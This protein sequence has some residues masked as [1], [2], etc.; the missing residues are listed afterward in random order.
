MAEI[1]LGHI[2]DGR[3][4]RVLDLGCG[5]GSLV[6][7]IAQA[8][9]L[10]HVV[11]LDI[12]AAN[13]RAAEASRLAS[14]VAARVAFERADYLAFHSEPFDA[15]VSD[16]VL[17]LIPGDTPALFA[18]IASDL[19]PRGAFVC[20]MPFD[21]GYNRVFALVRRALRLVKSPPVDWLI[22]FAAKMLHRREMDEQAL[23]ERV[24]YMYMPP[25]RTL[26][27]ATRERVAPS[28]G[29]R[30]VAQYPMHSTSPSQLR[31]NVTVFERIV[32]GV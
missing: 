4:I 3:P 23:R 17:H 1:A 14:S 9:P 32:A 29:L 10:A 2:P 13:I 27:R 7:R 24:D 26:D 30:V 12:S 20:G 31:H 5:T 15:I 22:L 16:G 25:T 8:R 28:V 11:G 6:F 18:R 21:C 19:R